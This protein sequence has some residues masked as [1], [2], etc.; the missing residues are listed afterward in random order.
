MLR[1]FEHFFQ[2][3][4]LRGLQLAPKS[5]PRH[6]W[7]VLAVGSKL[8]QAVIN[9]VEEDLVVDV[10][11]LCQESFVDTIFPQLFVS[12]SLEVKLSV[13][14]RCGGAR[15]FTALLPALLELQVQVEGQNRW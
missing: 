15:V 4:V 6:G 7:P 10:L 3:E 2:R 11:A 14:A 5:A 9:A 1:D 13:W 8:L 12:N